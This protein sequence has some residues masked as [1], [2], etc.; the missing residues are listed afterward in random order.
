MRLVCVY[1][2]KE[3]KYQNKRGVE[4]VEDDCVASV[5]QNQ[6]VMIARKFSARVPCMH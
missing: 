5:D 2:C 3:E 4:R 1:V 6:T